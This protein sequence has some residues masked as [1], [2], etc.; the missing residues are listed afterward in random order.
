MDSLF[1]EGYVQFVSNLN[2][3]DK[4][5]KSFA[6][7]FLIPESHVKISFL[8]TQF[9]LTRLMIGKA[10]EALNY[11]NHLKRKQKL[12]WALCNFVCADVE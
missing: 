11:T 3:H 8:L 10:L 5:V 9:F 2:V 7:K 4:L 1:L 6:D 12:K